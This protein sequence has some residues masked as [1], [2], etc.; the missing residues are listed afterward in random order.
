MLR[1]AFKPEVTSKL[2]YAL[3]FVAR[4]ILDCRMLCSIASHYPQFR[5]T[6][7]SPIPPRPKTSIDLECRID[8]SEAWA[9][10][11]G[12]KPPGS[13]DKILSVFR[14]QFK[15]DLAASY[16]LHAE[17]QLFMH[18]EDSRPRLTPT[19]SYFG[20]SKK[21]CLLCGTFL[22]V[23]PSPIATRGRHGICY[24]AWGIP[25]ARSAEGKTALRLLEKELVSRIKFLL[26]SPAPVRKAYFQ[27]NVP[28]STLVSDF[29]TQ[30]IQE[31]LQQKKDG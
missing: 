15:Q 18:Y 2:W 23:L 22:Q 31:R 1:L 25:Q 30:S 3:R 28:Q 11:A 27:S 4:P 5:D 6:R 7:V 21:S 19:H 16:S 10:L 24:P 26:D 29:S 20:C 12:T 9:R 8:I 13:H 14:G 17:I